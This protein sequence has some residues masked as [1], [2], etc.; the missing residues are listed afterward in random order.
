MGLRVIL[1]LSTIAIIAVVHAVSIQFFLYWKY[2]WLDIPVHAFAGV[3]CVFGLYMLP[4]FG[5]T[6]F[7]NTNTLSKSV[8]FALVVGLVW[9]VFEYTAGVSQSEPGFVLDTIIDLC[10]DVFGGSVGY[11]I[12]KKLDTLTS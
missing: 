11:F 3:A 10:M 7:A 8:L 5:I 6:R 12:S 2:V 4:Y 9:E 1:F